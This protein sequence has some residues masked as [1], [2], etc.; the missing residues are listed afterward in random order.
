MVEAS[1]SSACLASCSVLDAWRVRK[2]RAVGLAPGL[3]HVKQ[4]S[5]TFVA[6]A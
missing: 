3:R 5:V 1:V 6:V 4:L 2:E